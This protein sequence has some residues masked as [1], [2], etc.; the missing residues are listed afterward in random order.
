MQDKGRE[1][2]PPPRRIRSEHR[3][4]RIGDGGGQ[5]ELPGISLP[6]MTTGTA[7]MGVPLRAADI[8]AAAAWASAR[9]GCA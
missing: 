2:P 4:Q 6:G 7:G 1:M 8:I 3:T 5:V 9:I